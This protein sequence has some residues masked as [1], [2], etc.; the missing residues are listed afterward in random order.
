MEAP[1]WLSRYSGSATGWK[2]WGPFFLH[3]QKIL[4][5][6]Q[7]VQTRSDDHSFLISRY[8]VL[9]WWVTPWGCEFDHVPIPWEV[10][11]EYSCTSNT[12]PPHPWRWHNNLSEKYT[13]VSIIIIDVLEKNWNFVFRAIAHHGPEYAET[14]ILRIVGKGDRWNGVATQKTRIPCVIKISTKAW[15]GKVP[16]LKTYLTT[17]KLRRKS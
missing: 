17:R 13:V 12:P 15:V 4:L 6:F 11:D 5:F 10:K 16:V 2:I 8:Q 9:H 14:T 3:R 1:G 7:K